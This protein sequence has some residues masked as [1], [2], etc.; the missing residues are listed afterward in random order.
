MPPH[1]VLSNFL[2][3]AIFTAYMVIALLFW[4]SWQDTQDR[5][6]ALFSA[7]FAAL[8]VERV[9]LLLL[10]ATNESIHLVYLVRLFAYSLIIWAIVDK[11]RSP[12]K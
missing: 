6:F 10:G 12:Q 5:L 3:G 1:Y 8:G 9:V 4:R 7:A 2:A 11:N